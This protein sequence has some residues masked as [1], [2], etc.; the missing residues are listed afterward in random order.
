MSRALSAH[1]RAVIN[2][3]MIL[4]TGKLPNAVDPIYWRPALKKVTVR[5]GDAILAT[6]N[7]AL[8]V[9]EVS[10]PP[11]IYIPRE[12]VVMHE[13]GASDTSTYC[14]Y[15]GHASYFSSR[16]GAAKDVAWSYEDP[17]PHMSIIKGHLAFYPDRVD[18][19][20]T[21]L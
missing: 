11:V 7:N 15:K 12:D 9:K 6:S 1:L 18:A 13:L 21:A 5:L 14:P 8:I 4:K 16:D 2:R 19:I 3:R 17:C 10:L 20:E